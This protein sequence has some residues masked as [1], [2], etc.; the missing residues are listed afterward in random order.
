MSC[1][2]SSPK[3]RYGTAGVNV[4]VYEVFWRPEIEPDRRNRH[5]L[6]PSIDSP[7]RPSFGIC[8]SHVARIPVADPGSKFWK[9]SSVRGHLRWT[10]RRIWRVRRSLL[11]SRGRNIPLSPSEP[12]ES[13]QNGRVFSEQMKSPIYG[14]PSVR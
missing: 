5:K 7:D 1:L 3:R 6:R 4:G 14:W 8:A 13:T 10:Q 2:R 11:W 9:S 12:L